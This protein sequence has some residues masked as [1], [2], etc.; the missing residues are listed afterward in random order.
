M[1]AFN[2][3]TIAEDENNKVRPNKTNTIKHEVQWNFQWYWFKCKHLKLNIRVVK[4][5][6]VFKT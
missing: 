1:W 2:N 4:G 3:I 6:E 5:L